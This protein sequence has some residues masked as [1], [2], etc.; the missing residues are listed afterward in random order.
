VKKQAMNKEKAEDIGRWI[1]DDEWKK[2][3]EE[4]NRKNNRKK[5]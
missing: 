1:R 4:R 5:D 3:R 2:G